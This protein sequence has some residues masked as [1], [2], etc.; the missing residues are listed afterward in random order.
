MARKVKLNCEEKELQCHVADSRC[1]FMSGRP[2]T[3]MSRTFTASVPWACQRRSS[4]IMLSFKKHWKSGRFSSDC[5]RWASVMRPFY[6]MMTITAPKCSLRLLA[7]ERTMTILSGAALTQLIVPPRTKWCTAHRC[8]GRRIGRSS[9]IKCLHPQ[10]PPRQSCRNQAS[11]S[12]LAWIFLRRIRHQLS[13]EAY[14]GP[15]PLP[16]PI[17]G[18][19]DV[20]ANG[21]VAAQR[22]HSL[23]R[24]AIRTRGTRIHVCESRISLVGVQI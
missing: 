7:K 16:Q 20:Q 2:V 10:H 13:S 11:V 9:A 22:M 14:P 19:D 8:R 15:A 24:H 1:G 3:I 21:Y 5:T 4:W 17:R 12:S 18:L 6:G 23:L